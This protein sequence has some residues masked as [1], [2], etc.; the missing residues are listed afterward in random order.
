MASPLHRTARGR[1]SGRRLLA[2]VALAGLPVAALLGLGPAAQAA[3][4][5]STVCTVWNPATQP[6]GQLVFNDGHGSVELG[7]QFHSDIAGYATGVR[8]YKDASFTGTHLGHL[9]T[10][11]GT[12]LGG[13]TFT[14]ETASG[15]Q[16]AN[17]STPIALSPGTN[18]WV[19]YFSAD[20]TY[21][22]TTGDRFP[23]NNPPLHATESAFVYG[24]GFPS[25]VYP[26]QPNY[27]VDV[28]FQQ[29][30]ADLGITMQ[31]PGLILLGDRLTYQ[32]SV[33]NGGPG[34]SNAA[35]VTD[36]LPASS[37]FVTS[38]VSQ[39]SCGQSSGIVTCSLGSMAPG[40]K[41]SLSI[42]V[43]PRFLG[44]MT[45]RATVSETGSTD[46]NPAND[47]ASASTLVIL[48]L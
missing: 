24:G 32:I 8:F 33:T 5:C 11:S 25:N 41:A 35:Y 26:P 2:R 48:S 15:W 19:S 30:K 20:G 44:T 34:I 13:V 37:T 23:V 45:N 10:D 3:T 6:T 43:D 42:T 31:A 17:F 18:Y 27:W 46:P 39:G 36:T 14:A 4:D 12:M 28:A 21:T 22:A 7:M 40:A 38:T 29:P 47:T 1:S 16:Q 9:W